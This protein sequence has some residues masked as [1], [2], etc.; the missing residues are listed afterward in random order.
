MSILKHKQFENTKNTTTVGRFQVIIGKC[1]FCFL[2][3]IEDV[4][5][6]WRILLFTNESGSSMMFCMVALS[7]APQE[8]TLWEKVRTLTAWRKGVLCASG[9]NL[10]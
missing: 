8:F 2:H 1:C 4:L 5:S 3:A 6:P 10:D 9:A 7:G